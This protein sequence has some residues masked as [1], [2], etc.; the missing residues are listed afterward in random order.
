MSPSYKL[1]IPKDSLLTPGLEPG[2]ELLI[3]PRD[4]AKP[5]E[6]VARRADGNLIVAP[7]SLEDRGTLLGVVI[8]IR[9]P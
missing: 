5:G 8:G 4:R 7:Y 3:Q 1:Q 2:D 6:L 9:R